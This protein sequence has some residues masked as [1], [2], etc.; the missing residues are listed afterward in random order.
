MNHLNETMKKIYYPSENLSLD[1]SMV[2]R[3]GRLI[4]CRCI[5]N[6]KLKYG[7]KFYEL[8]ESRGLILRSFVYSGLPYPNIRDLGQTGAI[9][10][11]LMEDFLGKGY[12]VFADNYYNSVNL[13]NFTAP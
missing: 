7:V 9:I 2:L 6:K 13:T 5:K 12:T 10:L 11:K 1:E 3:R 8:C 4:F